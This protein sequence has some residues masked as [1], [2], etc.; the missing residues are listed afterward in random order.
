[1][2]TSSHVPIPAHLLHV[3]DIDFTFDLSFPRSLVEDIY[4]VVV[5]KNKNL[6]S[7]IDYPSDS[8]VS[9]VVSNFT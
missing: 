1:M 3:W 4:S 9:L 6:F 2:Y 8:I 7:V 5:R